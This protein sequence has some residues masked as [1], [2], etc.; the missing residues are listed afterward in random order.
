MPAPL[1]LRPATLDTRRPSGSDWWS[2]ADA[3]LRT[4]G[5]LCMLLPCFLRHQRVDGWRGGGI[6]RRMWVRRVRVRLR[7]G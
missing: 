4:G 5:A 6:W 1:N 3:R 7:V 2:Y